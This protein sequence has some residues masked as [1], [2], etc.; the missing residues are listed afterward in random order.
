M[1]CFPWVQTLRG[2]GYDRDGQRIGHAGYT[3]PG[4]FMA[5]SKDRE[6]RYSRREASFQRDAQGRY[7]NDAPVWLRV[8]ADHDGGGPPELGPGR[9]ANDAACGDGARSV[10]RTM[11]RP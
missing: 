3:A 9:R 4:V 7:R 1:C 10:R 6:G 8:I 2:K 5:W 11:T